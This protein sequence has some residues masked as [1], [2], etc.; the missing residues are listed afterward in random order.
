MK[1]AGWPLSCFPF[2]SVAENAVVDGFAH[3]ILR[4]LWTVLVC[5]YSF[6]ICFL[7]CSIVTANSAWIPFSVVWKCDFQSVLLF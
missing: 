7:K 1:P 3:E 2:S 4:T 6:E 5:F